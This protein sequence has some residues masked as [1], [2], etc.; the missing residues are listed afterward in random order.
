MLMRI[1]TALIYMT[2]KRQAARQ[3]TRDVRLLRSLSSGRV[4]HYPGEGRVRD[5]LT[6]AYENQE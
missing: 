6:K 2:H 4:Y 1:L 5:R 3:I